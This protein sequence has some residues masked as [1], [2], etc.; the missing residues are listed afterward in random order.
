MYKSQVINQEE[1]DS[2]DTAKCNLWEAY[3][4][5]EIIQEKLINDEETANLGTAL[6]GIV[7]TINS[8]VA[9]LEEI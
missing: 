5:L 7:K 4:L 1:L 2:F 8:S 3:C 6:R 9:L